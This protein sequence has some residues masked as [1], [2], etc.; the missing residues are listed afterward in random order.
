MRQAV[1]AALGRFAQ[2]MGP[3]FGAGSKPRR[4]AAL[5]CGSKDKQQT[6]AAEQGRA[7]WQAAA[8]FSGFTAFLYPG[9]LQLSPAQPAAHPVFSPLL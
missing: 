3:I 2:R 1:F 8:N 5:A 6:K 7:S 9:F 4:K